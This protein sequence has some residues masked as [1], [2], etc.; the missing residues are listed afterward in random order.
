MYAVATVKQA[1]DYLNHIRT[2]GNRIDSRVEELAHL[3]SAMGLN[4]VQMKQEGVENGS[5]SNNRDSAY[6]KIIE[7]EEELGDEI[8]SMQ[9][10]KLEA[11]RM[12]EKLDNLMQMKVLKERY[13]NNKTWQDIANSIDRSYRHT[14]KVHGWALVEFASMN[15][16]DLN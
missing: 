5:R 3:K 15:H 13:L 10:Q 14:L 4:A 6:L 2:L 1:K 7:L 16:I 8:V 12:I 11:C 9:R